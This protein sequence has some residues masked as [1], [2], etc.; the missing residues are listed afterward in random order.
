MEEDARLMLSSNALPWK[1]STASAS[2]SSSSKMSWSS[3]GF[4]PPPSS[5]GSDTSASPD[6]G[7]VDFTDHLAEFNHHHHHHHLHRHHQQH[8][9]RHHNH[10]LEDINDKTVAAGCDSFDSSPLAY[11]ISPPAGVGEKDLTITKKTPSAAVLSHAA[12]KSTTVPPS[13]MMHVSKKLKVQLEKLPL[14]TTATMIFSSESKSGER[15]RRCLATGS[16]V[17]TIAGGGLKCPRFEAPTLLRNKD[18]AV[19][20]V[21]DVLNSFRICKPKP[22]STTAAIN[23]VHNF[24]S[25]E[26]RSFYKKPNGGYP[27]LNNSRTNSS[28][29]SSISSV[30]KELLRKPSLNLPVTCSTS[31]S[32]TA[33][34]TVDSSC[35]S[36]STAATT[37]N[38]N[39]VKYSS[40]LSSSEALVVVAAT[41]ANGSV[42]AA[43][44]PPLPRSNSNSSDSLLAQPFRFPTVPGNHSSAIPCKWEGCGQG[45]KTHGKLSD[46]IKT[47]HMAPQLEGEGKEYSC[48]WLDCK[49][50]RRARTLF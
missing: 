47:A 16:P 17:V 23:A 3:G 7:F 24:P 34:V 38:N 1:S 2:S 31:E 32:A 45:F 50:R 5:T 27:T 49:V 22:A 21:A 9:H 40:S 18:I 39:T 8:N 33:A 36:S 41:I 25:F 20:C 30:S 42:V 13:A 44:V 37:V 11:F 46:H 12:H 48:L 4:P 29:V 10:R 26:P 35:I 6:L 14:A 28:G 43:A 19:P 15:K